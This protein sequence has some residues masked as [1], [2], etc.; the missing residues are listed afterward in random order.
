MRDD[1]RRPSDGL[2]WK[3]GRWIATAAL[4]LAAAAPCAP[5]IAAQYE[6][7]VD[8]PSLLGG[9]LVLQNQIARVT[10]SGY[11][12]E[13]TL[14]ADFAVAA[15]ARTPSGKWLLTP[16]V[17]V[18]WA[19][20]PAGPRDIVG[21]DPGTGDVTLLF[22][23]GA[24]GIPNGAAIDALLDDAAA[25]IMAVSFDAPVRLAGVDY[26]PSDLVTVGFG[27]SLLWSGVSAG[28]PAWANLVG[29]ERDGAGSLVVTFDVPVTLGAVTFLPGQLALWGGGTSFAPYAV[30]SAWPLGSI[31][32]DFAFLPGAGEVPDGSSGSVPLTV[33]PAA[34]GQITLSWGTSCAAT[35]TDYEVY[36]GTI[37]APFTSHV[38]VTCTTGGATTWTL[39]P[40]SGNTYYYVVPRNPAAEG[41][42]GRR[43]DGTA[44]PPSAAACI[45]QQLTSSCGK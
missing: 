34:G 28:V 15:M 26:G 25:G 8:V 38:P 18:T 21:W 29:A 22:D 39:T 19:G 13:A 7:A 17:P 37:G 45:P 16:E 27:F 6:L 40:S 24:A 4:M 42:Y 11:V 10:G 36:E 33:A 5:L 43:S 23:G 9:A 12:V 1:L 14:P 44:R 3:P 31:L 30:D 35:D 2:R 20:V 32:A 41:S